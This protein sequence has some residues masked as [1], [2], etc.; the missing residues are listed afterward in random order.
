[1]MFKRTFWIDAI[2]SRLRQF[3]VV[4]IVGSRQAGKTTMAAEIARRRR[5]G[6]VRLDLESPAD[7]ARLGDPE[8][9]FS[10]HAGD[11]V[12]L[13]EIQRMPEL[14]AVL[15]SVVDRRRTPGRFLVL[16]SA[17]PAMLAQT[18]ESL[19]GRI[20]YVDL[21]PLSLVEIAPRVSA[22]RKHE[23]LWVRGG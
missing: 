7:R 2:E 10:A 20:A 9:F 23:R 1:M 5:A 16:G 6:C 22:D 13:D 17:S 8:G 15:R 18:S 3:P 11:L 19:A 21:P 4:G 12:V 14:F